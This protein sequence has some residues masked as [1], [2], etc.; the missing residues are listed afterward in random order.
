M[1]TY[2]MLGNSRTRYSQRIGY[3]VVVLL[4]F[5]FATLDVALLLRHVLD[6]FIWYHGPGGAIGEFSDISYWVNAMKTVNSVAQTGIADGMLIYRCYIVFDRS[7]A[8]AV[9]L[10]VVWV[11]GLTLGAIACYIEFT[12]RSST[13]LGAKQ[14]EPFLI[15]GL[16][17][18]LGLNIIATLM[19]AYK[20]GSIE[21]QSRVIFG[22]SGSGLRRAMRI[23]IESGL[24][25]SIAII[26][27]FAVY[28]TSSNAEYAVSD[29]VSSL[30]PSIYEPPY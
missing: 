22:S 29:C 19:I 8:L 13:F 2:T 15:S 21:R 9:T 11:A 17:S 1:C 3:F 18:T 16:S 6:A 14:L 24:M 27:S 30:S 26:I 20:I 10:C 23:I 25:Y 28:A 4:L 5:V 7:W 12:L